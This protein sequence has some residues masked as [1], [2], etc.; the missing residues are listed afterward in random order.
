MDY[1]NKSDYP[2]LFV[3]QNTPST[4][5][6]LYSS[7]PTSPVNFLYLTQPD[8]LNSNNRTLIRVF[9]NLSQRYFLLNSEKNRVNQSCIEVIFREK[10]LRARQNAVFSL[11]QDDFKIEHWEKTIKKLDKQ[12][13]EDKKELEIMIN[14]YFFRTEALKSVSLVLKEIVDKNEV[15]ESLKIKFFSLKMQ[16]AKLSNEKERLRY[17]QNRLNEEKKR[18]MD[19]KTQKFEEKKKAQL[20]GQRIKTQIIQV[21]VVENVAAYIISQSH[22]TSSDHSTL[23]SLLS[24][25]QASLQQTQ[26]SLNRLNSLLQSKLNSLSQ[27]KQSLVSL[28]SSL[29]QTKSSINSLKSSLFTIQSQN[30]HKESYLSQSES[31]LQ[32]QYKV[33]EKLTKNM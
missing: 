32:R 11:L 27:R 3:R 16:V 26:N 23:K 21:S 2:E 7:P 24:Q 1:Y 20:E 15:V 6:S 30:S 31:H 17:E 5:Y 8:N 9:E 10:E 14:E 22:F 12:N 33:L 18:V 4:N 29:N 13:L 25:K 28:Q 19:A